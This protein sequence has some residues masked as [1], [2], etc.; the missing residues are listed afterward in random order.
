VYSACFC[1]KS[2]LVM[3]VDKI[4][5]ANPQVKLHYRNINFIATLFLLWYNQNKR[6]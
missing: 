2:M 3:L 1:G 5:I 6:N 4:R